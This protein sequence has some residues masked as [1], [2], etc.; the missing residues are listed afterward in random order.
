MQKITDPQDLA[1]IRSLYE[2]GKT[3]ME[4]GDQYFVSEGTIRNILKRQGV[5]RRIG[6]HASRIKHHDYFH[7][8]DTAKKAYFLGLMIADGCVT[9]DSRRQRSVAVAMML[10]ADDGYLLEELERELGS[11]RPSVCI[12]NRNEAQF[13][14]N[15]EQM[16]EDLAQ[17]GV[18]ERKTFHSYLPTLDDHL[19][20]HLIRGIFDGDG[21]V[22][23]GRPS[24]NNKQSYLKFSIYGTTLL[25]QQLRDYLHATIGLADNKVYEKETVSFISYARNSDLHAF[26]DY[27][28]G[29]SGPYMKRKKAVFDENLIG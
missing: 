16:A 29:V 20:V 4:L 11:N 27:I 28:Y 25:C 1:D 26:Y 22:Y 14:L 17:H 2:S 5:K 19:M 23:V 21:S 13:R 10:K 9:R 24:G 12:T 3:T 7:V 8:I 6:G 15:S 18:I